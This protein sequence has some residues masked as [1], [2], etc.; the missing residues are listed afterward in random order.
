MTPVNGHPFTTPDVDVRPPS[1]SREPASPAA[2]T[3]TALTIGLLDLAT[4]LAGFILG[5]RTAWPGDLGCLAARLLDH[6]ARRNLTATA[7]LETV[8]V[9]QAQPSRWRG[10]FTLEPEEGAYQVQDTAAALAVQ[11]QPAEVAGLTL[12]PND[13]P[14][15]LITLRPKEEVAH[16]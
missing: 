7:Q 11:F 1:S 12:A 10:P 16:A 15:L 13:E 6:L 3:H 14:P 9:G 4:G 2:G 8:I 5:R